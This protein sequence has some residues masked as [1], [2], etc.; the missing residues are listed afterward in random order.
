MS[1]YT[2][3]EMMTMIAA[4]DEKIMKL[5]DKI[6]EI[7]KWLERNWD[8]VPDRVSLISILRTDVKTS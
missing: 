2:R 5:D 8:N 7:E 4:S 3:Q 1:K 6:Q